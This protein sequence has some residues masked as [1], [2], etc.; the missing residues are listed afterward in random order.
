MLEQ[1]K[2]KRE[3]IIGSKQFPACFISDISHH[4]QFTISSSTYISCFKVLARM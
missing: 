2:S 1:S 4:K 3:V